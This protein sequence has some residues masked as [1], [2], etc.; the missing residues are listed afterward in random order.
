[1]SFAHM[2][3]GHLTLHPHL[4]APVHAGHAQVCEKFQE[5]AVCYVYDVT[6]GK[7]RRGQLTY[8]ECDVARPTDERIDRLAGDQGVMAASGRNFLVGDHHRPSL[9]PPNGLCSLQISR[10]PA[11]MR[12]I[13]VIAGVFGKSPLP[14]PL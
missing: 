6:T 12:P 11:W 13:A 9:C 7:R 14:A 10:K 4:C 2:S 1:M 3:S 8:G 5:R